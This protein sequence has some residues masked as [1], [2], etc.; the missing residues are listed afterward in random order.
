MRLDELDLKAALWTLCRWRLK[1]DEPHRTAERGRRKR[2]E[3]SAAPLPIARLSSLPT[4]PRRRADIP[5]ASANSTHCCPW[6]CPP[7]CGFM[8]CAGPSRA[9][10]ARLGIN[11]PVI[12]KVLNHVLTA[13]SPGSSVGISTP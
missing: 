4:A 2:A 12:E 1:P 11:L 13:A 7:G 8:I 5:R 3:G 9:A 10:W 6:T